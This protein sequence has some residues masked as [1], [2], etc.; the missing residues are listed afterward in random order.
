MRY[1]AIL[2]LFLGVLAQAATK[3]T[4]Y[5][6]G[7]AFVEEE[8]TI[9]LVGDKTAV[10]TGLPRTIV[11]GSLSWEGLAAA[12]WRLEVPAGG[13]EALV[14]TEVLVSYAGR[15]ARGVLISLKGGLVLETSEGYLLIPEY[16]S[17][18][19]QAR[20]EAAPL[21]R[22]RISLAEA[23]ASDHVVLRYLA[24]DLS[25]EAAYIGEYTGGILRLRGIAIL[26]N[27]SGVDFEDAEISLVAG[28][29]FGPKAEAGARFALEAM[30]LAAAPAPKVSPVGEYHRYRLPGTVDLWQGEVMAE[31]MPETPIPAEGIYRF[32][33][34]SIIFVLKFVNGTG[35]PLPAGTVRVFGEGAFLGEAAMGHT[36]EGEEAELPLG[37]AFDLT[38]ERTQIEYK[39]LAE[40]RY[41]E[42]YRITIRSA[43]EKTVTVEI[44]EEMR[45]QWRITRASLPYKVLDA[46]RVL[47]RL[48]VPANGEARLEYT[49][50]YTY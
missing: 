28:E 21:P 35:L 34:G 17:I 11:P 44:I 7:F 48:T 41:R 8:R 30:P 23:P 33:Y 14:G 3:V 46:Q 47:F 49:V 38:G 45:G 22:L 18:L 40:D 16:E 10:V 20:P 27:G 31:Y 26:R 9:E 12:E 43:K 1:F 32:S 25:W 2:L 6:G 42:S 50:E 4:L 24:Q 39:R 13:L 36:P 19:V 15:T 29:V 5:Q 37:V